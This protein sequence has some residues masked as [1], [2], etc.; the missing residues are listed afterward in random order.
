MPTT[1]PDI[2]RRC[3]DRRQENSRAAVIVHQGGGSGARWSKVEQGGGERDPP[4]RSR[5]SQHGARSNQRIRYSIFGIFWT[6]CQEWVLLGNNVNARWA[7]PCRKMGG[8]PRSATL[9]KNGD[10]KSSVFCSCY[11]IVYRPL[12]SLLT[13]CTAPLNPPH[14][15]GPMPAVWSP[16]DAVR[17]PFLST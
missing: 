12:R 5:R 9:I 15:V 11:P 7:F 10:H 3:P 14:A 8:P 6:G 13:L 1:S 4:F 17:E 16:G 2:G